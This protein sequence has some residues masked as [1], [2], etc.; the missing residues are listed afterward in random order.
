MS[1]LEHELAK[2]TSAELRAIVARGVPE[3]AAAAQAEL[4]SR[5]AATAVDGEAWI[6]EVFPQRPSL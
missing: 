3:T 6:R 5:P 2:L 1:L 4:D